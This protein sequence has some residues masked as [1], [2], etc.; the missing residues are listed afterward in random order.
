MG[1]MRAM[2]TVLARAQRIPITPIALITPIAFILSLS[3][4]LAQT[5]ARYHHETW[6]TEQGLPQNTVHCLR[7]T[8]DGY[9]WLGTRAGLARFD[10]VRF[11]V[12]DR[13]TTPALLNHQIRHLLEDRAGNLWISTPAALVRYRAGEFTAFTTKEGLASDNVWSTY[14]DRAGNLWVATLGG[15]TRYRDGKFSSHAIGSVEALLESRDGA[16][17][18][19]TTDGLVRWQHDSFTTFSKE[20]GLKG[21]AIKALFQDQQGRLWIGTT[22]GLSRWSEGRFVSVVLPPREIT[23]FARKIQQASSGLAQPTVCMKSATEDLLNTQ[24]PASRSM[25]ASR[26]FTPTVAVTCGSAHRTASVK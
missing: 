3:S 8:R 23:S 22:E 11:T 6:Q 26:R 5:P 10:G 2:R 20:D 13:R 21:N 17:W 1:V 7:Q 12:F 9:L 25:G 16:L 15:L 24:Q 18:I 19:G 4:V 14:E